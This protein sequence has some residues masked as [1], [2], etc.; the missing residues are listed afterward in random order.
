MYQT[1]DRNDSQHTEAYASPWASAARDGL[2]LALLSIAI[3]CLSIFV[4]NLPGFL[5]I[6]AWAVKTGGSIYLLVRFVK[7]YKAADPDASAFGYGIRVCL[8]SS[9]IIAAF[10]FVQMQY[11]QPDA[12]SSAFETAIGQMG[13]QL[14]S[15]SIDPLN[16]IADNPG[17]IMAIVTFIW[18]MMLGL[19]A[20]A[21]ISSAL[22]RPNPFGTTDSE[23]KDELL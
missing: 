11:I 12:V 1:E 19:L 23:Q 16:R 17:R 9:L 10:T 14:D 7:L 8:F 5:G 6:L 4:K 21:I 3:T 20:S 2:F 15:D 18:D 13:S 22:P